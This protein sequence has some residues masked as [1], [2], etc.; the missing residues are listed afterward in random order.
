MFRSM[1]KPGGFTLIEIMIAI[2]N[3]AI[4]AALLLPN[5]VRAQAQGL[6][7]DCK[8]NLTRIATATVMYSIDNAGHYPTNLGTITPNYLAAIPTCPSAGTTTYSD[9][10]FT[11]ASNPDIYTIVCS[12]A[13]HTDV[14]DNANYPRYTST[15]GLLE[16]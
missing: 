2:A 9:G 13:N 10:G 15:D 4:L 3:I 5:F 6:D 8:S 16:R 14:S 1:R 12:G 11:S 7:T